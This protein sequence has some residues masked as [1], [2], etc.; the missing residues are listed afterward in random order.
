MPEPAARPG[1]AGGGAVT[2]GVLR[3]AVRTDV[4]F[5]A[6]LGYPD[7][8]TLFVDPFTADVYIVRKAPDF[9]LQVFLAWGPLPADTLVALNETTLVEVEACDRADC[10]TD[11]LDATNAT[12]LAVRS[13]A[14]GEVPVAGDISPSGLGLLIKTYGRVSGA[15]RPR[16]LGPHRRGWR[17]PCAARGADRLTPSLTPVLCGTRTQMF[18]WCRTS[19]TKSFF[20]DT[21]IVV[22]YASEGQGEAVAWAADEKG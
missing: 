12:V 16:G 1:G 15:A 4:A 18:Y 8:E 6:H 2:H 7:A 11:A 14:G 20:S 9:P 3:G 17:K 5:P 13:M 10:R 19:A 22:P 21:P